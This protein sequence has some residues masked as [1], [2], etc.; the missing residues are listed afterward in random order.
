MREIKPSVLTII[1]NFIY[2]NSNAHDDEVLKSLKELPE[3]I[4]KFSSFKPVKTNMND[5]INT[6]LKDKINIILGLVD[7]FK[8]PSPNS[9]NS[10]AIEKVV[11]K[12]PKKTPPLSKNRNKVNLMKIRKKS[13]KLSK[14]KKCTQIKQNSKA[15]ST[16][17][18]PTR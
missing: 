8:Y 15:C 6:E 3:L 12:K 5:R 17:N 13:N 10:T 2:E 14:A 1:I 16:P 4:F 11:Q 9:A 7:Q 18:N